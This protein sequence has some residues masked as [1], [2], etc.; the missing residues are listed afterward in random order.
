MRFY[1]ERPGLYVSEDL[2]SG[3]SV[4]L[5]KS[6]RGYWNILWPDRESQRADTLAEARALV[7]V[8]AA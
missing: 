6:P 2:P 7:K 8:R 1:Q 3:G 4:V 5:M